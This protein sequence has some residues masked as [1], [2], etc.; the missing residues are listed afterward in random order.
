MCPSLTR[1]HNEYELYLLLLWMLPF[2]VQAAN[3]SSYFG[4]MTSSW[5]GWVVKSNNNS[6]HCVSV[7]VSF[8]TRPINRLIVTYNSLK[9]WHFPLTKPCMEQ[10]S[11]VEKLAAP[12]GVPKVEFGSQFDLIIQCKRDQCV[13]MQ[14]ISSPIPN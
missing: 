4:I 12:K 9:M 6:A 1:L 13:S 8:L 10:V 7:L 3:V 5:N 14:P 11:N 2:S